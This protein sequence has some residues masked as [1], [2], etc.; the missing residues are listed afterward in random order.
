LKRQ[1][2]ICLDEEVVRALE[3]VLEKKY[4]GLASRSAVI[5]CYVRKG[6]EE[7]LRMLEEPRKARVLRP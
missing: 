6:L 3:Y 1:V 4:G 7:D 5:E 2:S